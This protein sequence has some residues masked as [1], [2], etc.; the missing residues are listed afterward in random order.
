MDWK[1]GE[2]VKYQG[3]ICIISYIDEYGLF[4]E[5][6]DRDESLCVTR[7]DAAKMVVRY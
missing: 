4:L 7:E 3:R 2:Y 6:M 5:D 1:V